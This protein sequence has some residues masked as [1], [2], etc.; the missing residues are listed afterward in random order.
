MWCF[1]LSLVGGLF[2]CG[3]LLGLYGFPWCFDGLRGLF[4]MGLRG[5]CY[6]WRRFGL[7]IC[8]RWVCAVVWVWVRLAVGCA[9]VWV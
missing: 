3:R 7:L 2:I 8:L 4:V 9:V 6:G 5:W 1:G